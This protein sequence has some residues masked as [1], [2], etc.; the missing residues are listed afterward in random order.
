[1]DDID[2]FF[3]EDACDAF[4]SG[5]KFDVDGDVEGKKDFAKDLIDNEDM[6]L[7]SILGSN[8]EMK[9]GKLIKM[10]IE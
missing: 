9:E 10:T 7:Q 1:M 8:Y 2:N 4:V 5:I 6:L 3:G